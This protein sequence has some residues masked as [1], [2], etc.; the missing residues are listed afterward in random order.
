MN[1][2]FLS[3]RLIRSIAAAMLV[4]VGFV[5]NGHAQSKGAAES[6]MPT[7]GIAGA[8]RI[9]PSTQWAFRTRATATVSSPVVRLQDVVTPLDT[10]MAAWQRLAKS[11]IGLVPV[12]GQ[13][14]TIDRDRLTAIILSAEATPRSI[15][16]LGP[17]TIQVS[18][19]KPTSQPQPIQ[20]TDYIDYAEPTQ[21]QDDASVQQTTYQAVSAKQQ[22]TLDAPEPDEPPLTAS[23][24]RQVAH[25]IDLA[26][27]RFHPE[28]K[29]SYAIELPDDQVALRSLKHIVRVTRLNPIGSVD[30][31]A[32]RFQIEARKLSGP[33]QASFTASLTAHPMVVVTNR[34]LGRGQIIRRSDL[35]LSPVE[36]GQLTADTVTDIAALVGQETKAILRTGLPIAQSSVGSPI[37]IHRGDLIEVIVLGGGVRVSTNAKAVSNGA[38]G[39][40][41]ELETMNPK[42]R[43]VGRVANIGVAEITTR[44]PSVR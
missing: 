37:L 5:G 1:F 16:W 26:F 17:K 13:S 25:W 14:M 43:L 36:A 35:E 18:Y 24:R 39:E 4:L 8:A 10:R 33:V 44:T 2:I 23:E 29:E 30:E 21:S 40:L 28:I 7:A 9:D 32:C 41:I 27:K 38:R 19:A 42:K 3:I 11:P 6:E 20:N 22:N 34:T 12:G 15:E 31:G